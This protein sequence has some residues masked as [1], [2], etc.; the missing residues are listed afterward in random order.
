MSVD[1]ACTA[2]CCDVAPPICCF[3]DTSRPIE[4]NYSIR[5]SVY[6]G[7]VEVKRELSSG[8]IT[9]TMVRSSI[10]FG[11]YEM[12]SSGGTAQLRTEVWFKV[13]KVPY[14]GTSCAGFPNEYLCPTC[15]DF[16][17]CEYREWVY[18]GA[19][20][21][22]DVLIRCVDPCGVFTGSRKTF[23]WSF[24]P[25]PNQYVGT[26][27]ERIGN[28]EPSQVA[29]CGPQTQTQTQA[30]IFSSIGHVIPL[31]YGREGC[32]NSSTF[33]G[34]HA[35]GIV[36]PFT[37]F[38]GPCAP[39]ASFDAVIDCGQWSTNP[40]YTIPARMFFTVAS[41]P[42]LLCNPYDPRV[43]YGGFAQECLLLDCSGQVISYTVNGCDSFPGQFTGFGTGCEI[44]VYA[45]H[46]ISVS[47]NYG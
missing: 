12:R 42:R 27:I 5:T 17:D 31:V 34:G 47:I 15:N 8:S 3:P 13:S 46:S 28:N 19:L 22:S 16:V 30:D 18:S 20:F 24:S 39:N 11:Q 25:T 2:C 33:V 40:A 29:N 36:I 35:T 32:L 44:S 43:G 23:E 10:G 14:F 9:T 45:E 1:A 7:G 37:E 4:I 26:F 41:C 21:N 6:A 38:D